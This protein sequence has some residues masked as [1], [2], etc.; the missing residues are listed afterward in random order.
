MK[1]LPTKRPAG[2]RSLDE[3]LRQD[4]PLEAILAIFGRRALIY[5]FLFESS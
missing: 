3:L 4:P 5:F 2:Q 1:R